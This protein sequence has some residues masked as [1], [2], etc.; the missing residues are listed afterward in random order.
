LRQLD[1]IIKLFCFALLP[2]YQGR[3]DARLVPGS[4]PQ[5]IFTTGSLQRFVYEHE[6]PVG[7]R[8][9]IIGAERVSL[10][11]VLT[12]MHAG[13]RPVHM[14]TELPHHQLYLPIFLPAKILFADILARTQILANTRISNIFGRQCVEAIELMNLD[15]GKTQIIEC[16]TLVFTGDWIP[17]N[18]LARTAGVKTGNPWNGPQVDSQFRA[19]QPSIFA[20][21]NVLRGVETAD[22]AAWEGRRAAVSIAQFLDNASWNANRI[23]VLA[24]RPL[25]WVHPAV[26][27][28]DAVSSRFQIRSRQCR[29]HALLRVTQC[30]NVLFRQKFKL[31]LANTSIDLSGAWTKLVDFFR[32]TYKDPGRRC[33][34]SQPEH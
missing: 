14:I 32:R 13:L 27:S 28:P 20:A 19:S 10:S 30:Q 9:V 16:D 3:R 12:L 22:W 2:W 26:I 18:E 21:G 25:D 31:L 15:S 29:D 24:E 4:R 7:E 1:E 23:E 17:E 34:K 8:A 6:L 33:V 11:V 5:G